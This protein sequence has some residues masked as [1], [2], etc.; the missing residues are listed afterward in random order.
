[1][2][3]FVFSCYHAYNT[4]VRLYIKL[5]VVVSKL[6]VFRCDTLL[7]VGSKASHIH[8]VYTMHQAM[9]REKTTLL[10]VDGVGDV[11]SEAVSYYSLWCSG[12]IVHIPILRML[13][14]LLALR[15]TCAIFVFLTKVQERKLSRIFRRTSS[16][17]ASFCSAKDSVHCQE[18]PCRVSSA[19]NLCH[20][21]VL[22]KYLE[23][24]LYIKKLYFVFIRWIY[25]CIFEA[26][27]RREPCR[28]VWRRRTD[29][30]APALEERTK[31]QPT[32]SNT[33]HCS[34]SCIFSP[35]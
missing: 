25:F 6:Y 29:L 10:V 17:A 22:S 28:P 31:N 5:C 15:F 30:V 2:V 13:V 11:M 35:W 32:C 7:V 4:K 33:F 19:L 18:Y 3:I 1:M 34:C 24:I 16:H 12:L 23:T 21:N 20:L 14:C 26:W 8:T 27:K 9:N